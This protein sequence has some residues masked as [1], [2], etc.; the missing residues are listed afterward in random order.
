MTELQSSTSFSVDTSQYTF[1]ALNGLKAKYS[2][3]YKLLDSLINLDIW[4]IEPYM[5]NA[6]Y[7]PLSNEMI[8]PAGL[9]LPPLF[10]LSLP[11]YIRYATIGSIMGHEMT[12]GFDTQGAHYSG[13][14]KYVNWWSPSTFEQFQ[15][16]S[17]CFIQQYNQYSLTVSPNFTFP[18][19]GNLTLSENIADNGGLL[20]AAEAWKLYL[21]SPQGSMNNPRLLGLEKYSQHQLFYIS[22]AQ[23]WCSRLDPLSDVFKVMLVYYIVSILL[24]KKQFS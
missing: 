17:Q 20:R 2:N 8:I 11:A 21:N 5:L 13:S 1:S 12:H 24:Q 22:Y 15:T 7:K 16:K 4:T 18:V 6:V 19:S 23:N 9:L 14:G 3:T 10:D